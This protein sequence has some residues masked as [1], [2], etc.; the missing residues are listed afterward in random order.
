MKHLLATLLTAGL[1]TAAFGGG[2]IF[3]FD[4]TNRIPYAWNL[5]R[6]EN[7]EVPIYTDLG[8]LGVLTNARATKLVTIAANEWSSVPTSSFRAALAGDVSAQGLDDITAANVT[9]VI[10]E[11]NG[12]GIDVIYDSD[13]SILTNYFGLPPTA[14]LGITNVDFVE[15]NSPEILEAWM[16]LSGP[17][18][19][20]N[21]PQGVGFQGVVTHEMGHALNLAHSQA[22]GLAYLYATRGATPQ[23]DGCAAPWMDGPDASQVETMYPFSTPEPGDSGQYMGTVDRLD[24]MSALSD[25]YPAP[26][27]PGNR[28]TI[29]GDVLDSSGTPVT[30]VDI[31]ARNVADPFNDFTSYISGQVTKGQ[32]GPDGSFELNDLTP[33]ARYVIYTDNLVLGAFTVPTLVVLPGPEEYFNGGMESGDPATDDR[34]KWV[35]VPA[36]PG[37]PATANITFNRYA[38]APTLIRASYLS[39]PNDITP[40]GSIVV[41]GLGPFVF[42]WDLNADTF[43]NIGGARQGPASISDDATKIAANAVD[44]D[45]VSKPAIYENGVW[46]ILPPVP[47][48]IPC[49][50]DGSPRAGGSFDISG[51][52]STVVGMNYGDGCYRGG[53][54]GF[55]W[56]A[57]GG[58][59]ELPK[60]S[61]FNNMSRANAVNY[62]GSVIVGLDEATSGMWRGAY[63]KN[64]AVKLITRNGLNVQSAY[65]V[66]RDG[67]YI[68][69]QSAPAT[70]SNGWRYSVAGNNVQLLGSLP[71]Y[72]NALTLAI[73]DDHGVITG[74][75][76]SSG[77]GATSPTIW[78][79]G[80]H[81][82]NFNTFL[83]AQGVNL[84]DI[85]P[86]AP[87]AMSADGR[88]ITGV[89]ASIFGD[90]AFVVKTP[91]SIVCHAPAGSPTQIQT[92]VVS[93]PQGLD[94]ALLAG[95]TLGPCQC[96]ATAPTGI[97]ALSIRKQPVHIPEV[98]GGD[99]ATDTGD[100]FVRGSRSIVSW[101][102][103]GAASGYDLARGSLAILR[104]SYGDFSQAT[105]D[106]GENDLTGTTHDDADVPDV[107]D[108]FWYLI[109]AVNCGGSAT[110]DSGAPSQ[111][112]PRDAA[113]R[114]SA[115]ACP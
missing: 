77:T 94:A 51:D 1:A 17:G 36:Q 34:C 33:G 82:S 39:S 67:E 55:K 27:Y 72:D 57:A 62:D 15:A 23:P 111:V 96:G 83:T 73:S 81:W 26:G 78:T 84:T 112:R 32:I 61:S 103:I 85:Y 47:G 38:G 71:S 19:H 59:V 3:T 91:T 14:V 98:D 89:F 35:T 79:A 42:R 60:S 4:A 97:P 65:D 29:R 108:G 101:T 107:G 69:G 49:A 45:G 50:E 114:A 115:S 52:G 44:T 5:A 37:V 66:S 113:I 7:G 54:R 109:R 9:D 41:G 110:F 86:Y 93:F 6:W 76:T 12:G 102:A 11:W 64:G 56:T 68:V 46:T 10:G 31:V 48:S 53:I 74:Y 16:V 100:Q 2:P 58:S 13:G 95:D 25:L 87:T 75:T 30:G 106:C 99:I 80:L 105:T 22:N 40:D 18:I 21:D 28:G 43:E 63:W 104:S 24:D 88:V 90:I 92:T 70:S 8:G 20:A